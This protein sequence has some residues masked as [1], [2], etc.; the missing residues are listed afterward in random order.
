MEAKVRLRFSGFLN[1][2]GISLKNKNFDKRSR[3]KIGCNSSHQLMSRL[4]F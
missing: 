4:V 1:S 3:S 2:F